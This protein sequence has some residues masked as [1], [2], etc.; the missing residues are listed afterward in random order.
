MRLCG[1]LG[2]GIRCNVGEW[3]G[4]EFRYQCGSII[5]MELWKD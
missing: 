3:E 4:E 1:G 5:D 2:I